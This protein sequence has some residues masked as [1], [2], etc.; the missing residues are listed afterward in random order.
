MKRSDQVVLY[1]LITGLVIIFLMI[2]AARIILEQQRRPG[3]AE[4]ALE[5]AEKAYDLRHFD[6]IRADGRFTIRVERSDTFAVM[7]RYP[8]SLEREL[9]VE[10][11][12]SRL[13]LTCRR[14]TGIRAGG[15]R[16]TIRMPSLR[17]VECHQRSDLRLSGFTLDQLALS[18]DGSSEVEAFETA[19]RDL[20]LRCTGA[21]RVNLRHSLVSQANLNVNGAARLDLRMDGGELSGEVSGASIIILYGEANTRRLITSGAVQI[22]HR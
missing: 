4:K 12:G 21:A 9:E 18:V 14:S 8:V 19:V 5:I 16:V 2:V 3:Y 1:T 11:S 13:Y 7:L 10:Q 6:V 15:A 20:T 22:R 17:E